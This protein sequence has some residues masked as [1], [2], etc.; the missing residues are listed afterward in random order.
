MRE[1]I[2]R[3]RARERMAHRALYGVK[4]VA[5]RPNSNH[6]PSFRNPFGASYEDIET[7]TDRGNLRGRAT[8]VQNPKFPIMESL[9]YSDRHRQAR[10][11]YLAPLSTTDAAMVC[12]SHFRGIGS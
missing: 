8:D 3:D 7:G 2:G 9:Q 11:I 12:S 1:G 4:E 5:D 10:L 6:C